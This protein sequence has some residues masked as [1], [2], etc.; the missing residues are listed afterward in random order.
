MYVKHRLMQSCTDVCTHAKRVLQTTLQPLALWMSIH[1]HTSIGSSSVGNSCRHIQAPQ[2]SCKDTGILSLRTA[3]YLYAQRNCDFTNITDVLKYLT[4]SGL[5]PDSIYHSLLLFPQPFPLVSSSR[6][7]VKRG[8]LTAFVEDS[9]IFLKRTLRHQ[10]YFFLFND[11][12]IVTRKK[13]WVCARWR[14]DSAMQVWPE[15]L[16]FAPNS[17]VLTCWQWKCNLKPWQWG[18]GVGVY[19]PH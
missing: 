3:S 8:E 14:R 19:K 18:Q 11:V 12:F 17:P 13:R 2:I 9:G 15:C 4:W 1:I 10:V 6:W 7:M 16:G 5:F